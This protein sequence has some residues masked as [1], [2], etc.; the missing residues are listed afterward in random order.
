MIEDPIQRISRPRQ[1]YAGA[2][3]RSYISIEAR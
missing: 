2:S 3:E 1:L